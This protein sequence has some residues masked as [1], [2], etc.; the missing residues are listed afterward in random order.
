MANLCRVVQVLTITFVHNLDII[1]SIFIITRLLHIP[2]HS[3]V[4]RHNN[5]NKYLILC[6]LLI[7]IVELIIALALSAIRV[8]TVV[9]A[10]YL[11]QL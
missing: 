11:Q 2:K 1:I 7:S 9:T 4:G 3:S 5:T 8:R 10:E 6:L